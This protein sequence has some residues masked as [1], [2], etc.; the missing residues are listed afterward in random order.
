MSTK[1]HIARAK[2]KRYFSVKESIFN[3]KVHVFVNF[4]SKQF[5]AFAENRWKARFVGEQK[6]EDYDA[7]FNAFSWSIT[8]PYG[9]E[10]I[11]VLKEFDWCLSDQNILIHEI[12]HTIIKICD[13]NNI[14][15]NEST[16]E[17]LAHSVGNLYE[18]IA[19]IILGTRKR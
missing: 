6:H 17:F 3:R 10:W 8:G 7:E 9:T 5:E 1:Q 13:S 14:K 2:Q 19:G 18:D 16:Q 15:V 11:I 4:T 12:T